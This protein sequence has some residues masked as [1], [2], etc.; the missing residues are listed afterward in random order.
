M[1]DALTIFISH[2]MPKDSTAASLVGQLIA[3]NSGSKIKI[4]AAENFQKGGK[5]DP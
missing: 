3:S 2:K 4:I 5:A 1:G